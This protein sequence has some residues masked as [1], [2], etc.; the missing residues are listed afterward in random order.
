[1]LTLYIS[2]IRLLGYPSQSQSGQL[3]ESTGT[4]ILALVGSWSVAIVI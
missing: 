2:V 3:I 1:M 4:H